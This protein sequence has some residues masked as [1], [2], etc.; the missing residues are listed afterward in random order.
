[1]V[2]FVEDGQDGGRLFDLRGC[3]GVIC[4]DERVEEFPERDLLLVNR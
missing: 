2:R 4:K 1:M 3:L